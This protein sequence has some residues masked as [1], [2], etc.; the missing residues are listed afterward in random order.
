ML[1]W[2]SRRLL[3]PCAQ[4]GQKC[5]LSWRAG[6]CTAWGGLRER[7]K[8]SKRITVCQHCHPPPSQGNFGLEIMQKPT[9]FC[10]SP[11]SHKEGD[12]WCLEVMCALYCLFWLQCKP[13]DRSKLPTPDFVCWKENGGCLEDVGFGSSQFSRTP[14]ALAGRGW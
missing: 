9:P 1:E 11:M 5:E 14:W 12:F 3:E 4:S 2:L 7:I 13:N 8:C 10:S 6:S